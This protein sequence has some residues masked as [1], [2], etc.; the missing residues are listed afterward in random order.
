MKF[1]CDNCGFCCDSDDEHK[2][3]WISNKIGKRYEVQHLC[4][5]CGKQMINLIEEICSKKERTGDEDEY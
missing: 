4:Y 3:I 2:G 5:E 1:I